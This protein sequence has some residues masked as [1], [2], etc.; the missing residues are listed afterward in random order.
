[1]KFRYFLL[2]AALVSSLAASAQQIDRMTSAVLKSYD[3]I[4]RED[5]KD[6]LTLYDRASTYYRLGMYDRAY[7]DITRALQCTP[8]RDREYTMRELSM[9]ADVDVALK[10]YDKALSAVNKALELDPGSY[11]DVYRKGNILLYMNQPQEAYRVFASMQSLKSRSQE[12]YMG[13][14]RAN[15]MLGKEED[16]RNL[17]KE[18]ENAD[19][20]NPVTFSRIGDLYAEMGQ[21]E[22]AATNYIMAMSLSTNSSRAIDSLVKL[23]EKDYKGV[24]DAFDY[25][26][27]KT[28]NKA[29][30]L[31]V[32]ADLAYNVGNYSDADACLQQLLKL[33]EGKVA[34][35]YGLMAENALAMNRPDVAVEYADMAS[36]AEPA[37]G[38]YSVLRSN[39]L[40]AAGNSA[41]ALIEAQR[42]MAAKTGE[43]P[44]LLAAARASMS[45]GSGKEALKYLNEA[46]VSDPGN[47]ESLLLRAYVYENLLGDSRQAVADYQRAG[48]ADAKTFPALAW[49]ALAKSKAG[50]K[51]DADGMVADA[52]KADNKPSDLYYAAVYYSQ[53]GNLEKGAE[54]LNRAIAEGYQNVYNLK[55]NNIANLNIAP[56][57]HM[58]K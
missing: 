22:N 49:K 29:P 33:P 45:L 12:S 16:A 50:K 23:A 17:I 37:D 46:V 1:M 14:A 7:D 4:L 39:V 2:G 28:T 57:R 47:P 21:T 26:I 41:E 27:S 36:A 40:N 35:V 18:V 56:I 52:L 51:L 24:A 34:S 42:A 10:E 38:Y 55:V 43:I 5:P 48:S 9:L 54:L 25:S 44:A 15:I 30:L 13:M 31:F 19:P 58:V 20:S 32:K 8:E 6:Y 3:E 53:T 11:A